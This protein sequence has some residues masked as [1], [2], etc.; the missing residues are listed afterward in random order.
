MGR[1][2]QL[3]CAFLLSALFVSVSFVYRHFWTDLLQ[4]PQKEIAEK[5]A[6]MEVECVWGWFERIKARNEATLWY[7]SETSGSGCTKAINWL[8][9]KWTAS[10]LAAPH[11]MPTQVIS[12]MSGRLHHRRLLSHA[13]PVSDQW[14][15]VRWTPHD[16]YCGFPRVFYPEDETSL[17]SNPC[18]IIYI[19]L[20]FVSNTTLGSGSWQ[21]SVGIHWATKLTV[22][23]LLPSTDRPTTEHSRHEDM[24]NEVQDVPKTM[25]CTWKNVRQNIRT[26]RKCGNVKL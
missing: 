26:Q 5:I 13:G 12:L 24:C 20:N 14:H 16:S 25:Y 7:Q 1:E 19:S 2:N 10:C 21:N 6:E 11:S 17:L 8:V 15:H 4:G 3:L 9:T 22:R 18:L 23:V